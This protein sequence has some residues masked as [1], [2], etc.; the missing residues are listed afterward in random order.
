MKGSNVLMPILLLASVAG[1]SGCAAE[2]LPTEQITVGGVDLTVEIA[3]EPAER[4]KGLMERDSLPE[5]H[6]MLFV[7]PADQ[8]MSFWMKNTTIPLSIAYIASDG[9]ILEI[10]DL[11]P[12][13][14]VPVR[15]SRSARY[16]L[17]VNQGMFEA[18]GVEE[19]DRIE[20]P[21]ALTN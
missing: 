7:F 11:T 13:S 21:A 6:G 20:L 17:E 3:D 10:H 16:A 14:E 1:L 9:R 2:A 15:S 18:W 8:E 19:G 4:Q 12:L 5:D